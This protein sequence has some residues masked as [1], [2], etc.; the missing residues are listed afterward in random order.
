MHWFNI[1]PI[2]VHHFH[3]GM[4]FSSFAWA[5][6]FG[7]VFSNRGEVS[8]WSTVMKCLHIIL[9]LFVHC[10]YLSCEM[11][12]Y[13]HSLTSCNIGSGFLIFFPLNLTKARLLDYTILTN[14]KTSISSNFDFH[15]AYFQLTKT[16]SDSNRSNNSLNVAL[17]KAPYLLTQKL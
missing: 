9:I 16:K 2:A 3:P 6:I 5:E 13:H 14:K 12:S 11:K 10:F 8:T 15:K 17:F 7:S 1:M 4:A